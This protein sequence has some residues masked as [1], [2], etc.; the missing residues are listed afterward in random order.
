MNR[1]PAASSRRARGVAVASAATLAGQLA[2]II[3]TFLLLVFLAR[4][5]GVQQYAGAV[6]VFTLVGIC[7]L[8]SRAGLPR[9]AIRFISQASAV[10][11]RHAASIATRQVMRA[12]V[13][14]AA[15]QF[16]LW[17]FVIVPWLL[18]Q[19][20]HHPELRSLSPAI[21]GCIAL[22]GI[23]L[24]L[25]E[26]CR[27]HHRPVLAV[28]YGYA[29]RAAALLAAAVLLDLL[30]TLTTANLIMCYLGA[31]IAASLLAAISLLRLSADGGTHPKADLSDSHIQV[32]LSTLLPVGLPLMLNDICSL[33]L[34]QG[35]TLVASGTVGAAEVATYNAT[36]RVVNLVTIPYLALT[37]AL[38]PVTS[39]LLA[40]ERLDR[41]QSLARTASFLGAVPTILGAVL[42]LAA[43]H[44]AVH[45]LFGSGF[46]PS[47]WLLLALVVGPIAN[48]LTGAAAV[49]L[50]MSGHH[51]AN[52]TISVLVTA[53][54]ISAEVVLGRAFGIQGIAV[55]S[56]AG[57]LV[58]NVA[59][60]WWAYRT[61]G[62]RTWAE[63]VPLREVR[64]L[65]SQVLAAR[66]G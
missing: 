22:E 29:A 56:G 40:K 39:E 66:R 12:C 51:K 49:V 15:V 35:D 6:V 27:A 38:P 10:S 19:V 7:A 2:R 33:V 9:T 16:P 21:A 13:G 54:T 20:L 47:V 41:V 61:L 34:S 8:I 32:R 46:E 50:S 65:A 3:F 60:A 30:G 23:Q 52:M 42:L 63:V 5:L 59:M 37:F 45:A 36:T 31:T 57:T 55:A 1:E 48:A 11:G 17:A 44:V 26:S 53:V 14:I 28:I 62:I 58:L 18:E 25:A 43:P 24:T 4:H 64:R